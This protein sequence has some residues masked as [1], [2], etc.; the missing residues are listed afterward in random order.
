MACRS[1]GYGLDLHNPAMPRALAACRG[2]APQRVVKRLEPD[3]NYAWTD[4]TYLLHSAARAAGATTSTAALQPDCADGDANCTPA[5]QSARTPDDL[6]PAAVVH[7]RPAG[8]PGRQRPAVSRFFA[9]ARAGRCRPS[10]GSY[11]TRRTPSTRR[12][13]RAGRALRD[14]LVDAVD[15]QPRLGARRRSSSRGTTGAA[16]TTTSRRR[17]STSNGYGLRVP[18]IVISPYAR[19][20]HVDHQ[21]LSFDAFNKFIEDDFLRR[22]ADR[23]AHRRPPGPAARRA[24]GRSPLLGDLARDFDFRQKPIAPDPLPLHPRPGPQSRP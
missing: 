6:E 7:D 14:A 10:R 17:R 24:R 23:P 22:A 18:G 4:L 12:R 9:A 13:H 1:R 20:G 3:A 5:Q 21:M 8:P 19:R 15:A 16:S 11:P 2:I